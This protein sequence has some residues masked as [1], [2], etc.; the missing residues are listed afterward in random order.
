[1][2]D[3]VLNKSLVIEFLAVDYFA[4]K[5]LSLMFDGVLNIP[6]KFCHFI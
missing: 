1:M 6:L 3:W 4:K 2:F 5:A